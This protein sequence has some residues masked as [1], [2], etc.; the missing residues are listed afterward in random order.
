[1][2]TIQHA[3]CGVIP[4]H[5]LERVAADTTI[6]ASEHARAT[7]EHMRELATGRART[8]IEHAAAASPQE[9]RARRGRPKT[10]LALRKTTPAPGIGVP[11]PRLL[12]GNE[13]EGW[14]RDDS[15]P[16]G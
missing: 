16:R 12:P 13:P 2:T 1:M 10:P 7:L 11:T 14:T 4:S 3:V 6:E 15:G 8:L 9:K 5:M